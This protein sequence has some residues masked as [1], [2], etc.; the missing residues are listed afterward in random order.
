VRNDNKLSWND[1]KRDATLLD[2]GLD[3]AD[4]ANFGCD[5]ALTAHHDRRD[6]SEDRYVSIGRMSDALVVCVWCYRN[7]TTRIISL[8]KANRR[9]RSRYEQTVY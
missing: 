7:E 3:F 4:M 1:A 6:Y 2:R 9:E 8:R 5:S